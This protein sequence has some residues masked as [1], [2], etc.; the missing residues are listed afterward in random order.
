[1]Q[2]AAAASDCGKAKT[3]LE[4][5]AFGSG[6]GSGG[7]IYAAASFDSFFFVICICSRGWR[8]FYFL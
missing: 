5:I 8:L 6:G 1:L 7:G 3:M 2:N 4:P